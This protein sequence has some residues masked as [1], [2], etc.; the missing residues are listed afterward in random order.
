MATFFLV[1]PVDMSKSSGLMW[2][3]VPNRGGRVTIVS[4]ERNFGD[5]GLSSGWQGDNAG[6][7]AQVFP[8]SNDYAVVPVA[9]N[10][11][12]TPITGTVLGRIVNRWGPYS[13]PLLVQANPLPY[14]PISLDTTRSTLTTHVHETSEG[15]VHG[16]RTIPSS[17]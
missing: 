3:D 17:D 5:V 2:H 14:L 1:K 8:N 12:G 4:A 7:T 16:A 13:M 9:A 11:D 15:V 6:T 10:P